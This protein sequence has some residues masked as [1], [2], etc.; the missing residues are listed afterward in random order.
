MINKGEHLSMQYA[1][2]TAL[3]VEAVK[4]VNRDLHISIIYRDNRNLFKKAR[5]FNNTPSGWQYYDLTQGDFTPGLSLTFQGFCLVD[6]G[7]TEIFN[8]SGLGVGTYTYYFAVDPGGGQ[9]FFKSVVVDIYIS[10]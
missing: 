6:F 7:S 4:K 2:I 10:P 5:K 3:L 9:L 1:P 8:T